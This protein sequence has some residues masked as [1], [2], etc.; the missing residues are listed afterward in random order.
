[1]CGQSKA[2]DV[3][4]RQNK[5]GFVM[6][7][8]N[9]ACD[10]TASHNKMSVVIGSQNMCYLAFA[11]PAWP[12]VQPAPSA[13]GVARCHESPWPASPCPAQP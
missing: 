6:G 10:V 13:A 1:M 11:L 4:G 12:V 9:K 7:S 8:Q 5:N 3:T 2:C